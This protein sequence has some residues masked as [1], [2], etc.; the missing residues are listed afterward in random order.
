MDTGESLGPTSFFPRVDVYTGV[1]GAPTSFGS[2]VDLISASSGSGD[3]FG[4]GSSVTLAVPKG[5]ISGGSLSSSATWDD[6]TFASLCVT[7][8]T[9]VWNWGSGADADSFTLDIGTPAVPEPGSLLLLGTAL[10]G[11]IAVGRN[12]RRPA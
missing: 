3:Y 11:L 1:T 9:Y 8:G 2:G 10:I 7:Q 6:Q 4:S 5:Y 12:R